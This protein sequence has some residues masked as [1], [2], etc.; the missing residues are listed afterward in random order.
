MF[1]LAAGCGNT[2]CPDPRTTSCSDML[3][4]CGGMR[5]GCAIGRRTCGVVRAATALRASKRFSSDTNFSC[6]MFPAAETTMLPPV[7]IE[8]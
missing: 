2:A 6:V 1:L 8:R 3:V 4:I 5:A 7:Y